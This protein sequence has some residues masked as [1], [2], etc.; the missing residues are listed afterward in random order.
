MIDIAQH[1]AVKKNLIKSKD[2]A[3]VDFFGELYNEGIISKESLVKFR[4][5]I[6]F[7]NRIVHFYQEVSKDEVFKIILDDLNEF[8]RFIKEIGEYVNIDDI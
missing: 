3:S 2:V 4:L 1:I 7:R 6:R 8:R 5:M